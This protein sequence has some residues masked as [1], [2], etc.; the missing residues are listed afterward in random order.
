MRN[1]QP[2]LLLLLLLCACSPKQPAQDLFADAVVSRAT[3]DAAEQKA[4]LREAYLTGTAQAPIVEITV[5]AAALIVEQTQVSMQKTTVAESWTPTSTPVPSVT[6]S[7][8][9]NATVTAVYNQSRA[10]STQTNLM[11]ERAEMTNKAK[12]AIG[13]TT[14][15]VI[16]ALGI[17]LAYVLI[18]RLSI[19]EQPLAE[20]GKPM[21][22]V[23]VIDAIVLDTDRMANGVGQ[24]S[25]KFIKSLP[26]ITAERQD[27]VVTRAQMVD[28]QTRR[29]RLPKS[30]LDSQSVRGL[31]PDPSDSDIAA[32][33]PLPSWNIIDGWD[34]KG[35][36]YYTG[37][38]LMSINIEN[39]P[40]L[41]ILG[42][43]G[44]GKSRRFARPAIACA[45]AAGN[46]GASKCQ[47]I[48]RQ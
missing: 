16:L 35:I 30:L 33:F 40:H 23:N 48:D 19:V 31:L 22:L 8:T 7:P 46:R 11:L 12:A 41:A 26:A 29:A 3:A 44:A 13:Y 27:G 36:P 45:L 37:A 47:S 20:N 15:F 43:S 28:M 5:K 42:W 18:K 1:I 10:E 39:N 25:R 24:L 32:R 6:P 38:G 17:A 14:A 2:Y 9:F 4:L 21:P 34:G